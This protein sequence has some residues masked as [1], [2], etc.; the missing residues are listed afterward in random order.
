MPSV[1]DLSGRNNEAPHLAPSMAHPMM[2]AR[3]NRNP[4]PFLPMS[5]RTLFTA[6]AAVIGLAATAQ[7]PV[8]LGLYQQG[9]G[10]EIRVRPQSDFDGIFSNIVFTLRWESSSGAT[11]GQVIQQKA[12]TTYMPLQ[13]SGPVRQDG[14]YNYQVYTG[15]GFETVGSTGGNWHAGEEYTIGYIPYTG[16]AEFHI[17]DDEWTRTLENNGS[18]YISLGGYDK[19]GIIYKSLAG[20]AGANVQLSITPNPSRGQFT[21]VMPVYAN[22]AMWF[23]VVN[24][25]GQVVYQET[26]N[27][28]ENTYRK[29]F[30]MSS[31]GAGVYHLRIHRGDKTENHR[32]VIN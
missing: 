30:D 27:A 29:D 15:F 7:Q 8:D 10:L 6:A 20:E 2:Q 17:A 26:P 22:E 28:G 1:Y 9:D 13:P 23:E 25:A 3:P 5:F 32:V 16:K 11:L 18:Y 24:S 21:V 12:S 19:T 14:D 4:K 31:E